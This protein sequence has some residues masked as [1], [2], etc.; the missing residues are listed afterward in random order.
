[1]SLE[2]DKGLPHPRRFSVYEDRPAKRCLANPSLL[3][4]CP[5][6]AA[7]RRGEPSIVLRWDS[8]EWLLAAR[9]TPPVETHSGPKCS[10]RGDPDIPRCRGPARSRALT[11]LDPVTGNNTTLGIVWRLQLHR[12]LHKAE[13]RWQR[14]VFL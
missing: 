11:D 4:C 13:C 8:G 14:R 9:A 6:I 5:A 1:M 3:Q 10:D 2:R 7:R 12:K